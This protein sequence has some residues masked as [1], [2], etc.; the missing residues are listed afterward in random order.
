MRKGAPDERPEAVSPFAA[1][2]SVNAQPTIR[3]HSAAKALRTMNPGAKLCRQ[4]DL[5][6]QTLVGTEGGQPPSNYSVKTLA[7]LEMLEP[8]LEPIVC[9]GTDFEPGCK[10]H[11]AQS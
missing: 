11:D 7:N 10:L 1:P 6:I 5:R 2:L 8:M 3:F 9:F 4:N